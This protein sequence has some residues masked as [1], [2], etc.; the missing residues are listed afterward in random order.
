V[1]YLIG[2][3]QEGWERFYLDLEECG[4]VAGFDFLSF[5]MVLMIFF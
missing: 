2:V 3:V 1:S 5:G 4:N